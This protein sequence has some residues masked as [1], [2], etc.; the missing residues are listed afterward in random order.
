MEKQA[1]IELALSYAN[2][3]SLAVRS[4]F[5]AERY[6]QR[7]LA[8]FLEGLFK[9]HQLQRSDHDVL[10]NVSSLLSNFSLESKWWIIL[11]AMPP[12]NGSNCARESISLL[13]NDTLGHVYEF[14]Q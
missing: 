12:D 8:P 4:I 14:R 7:D 1:A 5:L 13:I 9:D 3:K 10:K 6:Q 11:F 2:S